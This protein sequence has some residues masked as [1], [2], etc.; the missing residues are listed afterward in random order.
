M[1]HRAPVS[2]AERDVA[3][4]DEANACFFSPFAAHQTENILRA[5]PLP[6]D[7]ADYLDHA[8][9]FQ[10]LRDLRAFCDNQESP[11]TAIFA[12]EMRQV[13]PENAT[14]ALTAIRAYCTPNL[15]LFPHLAG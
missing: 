1:E 11:V 4:P 10:V 5:G 6:P 13:G 8:S 15:A 9:R 12:G 2:R 3:V 14:H 7:G